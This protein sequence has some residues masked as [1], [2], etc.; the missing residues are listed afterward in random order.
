MKRLI[1]LV[2]TTVSTVLT[3]S[4]LEASPSQAALLSYN[5]TFIENNTSNTGTGTFQID[6][7]NNIGAG[8]FGVTAFQVKTPQ[9]EFVTLADYFPSQPGFL[10]GYNP[11]LGFAGIGDSGQ[12]IFSPFLDNGLFFERFSNHYVEDLFSPS[13]TRGIYVVTP[14]PEP[15][16]LLGAGTALVFGTFFKREF[17]K[18]RK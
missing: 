16:I 10:F 17:S 8:Y 6:D 7:T 11:T 15:I 1:R 13:E 12:L 3:L 4:V 14:V 2:L 9:G 18:K 5:L